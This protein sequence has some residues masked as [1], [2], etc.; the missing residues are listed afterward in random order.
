[1]K[2]KSLSLILLVAVAFTACK[3]KDSFV[4]DGKFENPGTEKKVFLYGMQNSNMVA[5]DSTNLS[6]KGEFKFIRK[7]PSVEFFRV[8]ARN[9]EFMVIG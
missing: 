8:L 3:P 6:E 2:L 4:I 1:M 9:H 5:I 7:T